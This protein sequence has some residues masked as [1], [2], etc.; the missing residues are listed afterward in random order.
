MNKTIITL[1][2]LLSVMVAK[3]Q[4]DLGIHFLPQTLQSQQANPALLNPYRVNIALPSPSVQLSH[5]GFSAS[6][7][8]RPLPGTDSL[9]L[10][11][12]E[13]ISQLADQNYVRANVRMDILGLGLRFNNL[14]VSLTASARAHLYANYPR[15][16]LDLAWRGNAAFLGQ[17][18]EIGPEFA[19]FAYSELALGAAY[20]FNNLTIGGRLKYLNGLANAE[21]GSGSLQLYTD[22]EYYQ[23]RGTLDYSFET[24]LIDLGTFDNFSP[25]FEFDP[26]T[27]NSGF[28]LDIGATYT[29]G[30]R[31]QI[32]A[33]LLD[34][35]SINWN[36]AARSYR[37]TGELT[38]DGIDV[39][40]IALGDSTYLDRLRDSLQSQIVLSEE[41]VQ[42]R[43]L[44]PMQ[45]MAGLRFSPLSKLHINGLIYNERYRGQNYPGLSLGVSKDFG[46]IFTLGASYNIRHRAYNQLGLQMWLRLGPFAGF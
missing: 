4:I 10:N 6:Q 34:F 40:A 5:S 12:D 8:L 36:D 17:S 31:L 18:L 41:P 42:Y 43:T 22:E 9:T 28:A 15:E 30:E 44:L 46:K 25:S 2:L 39:A 21:N 1:C 45:M 20:Q 3:A 13:V 35:G 16:L 37:A 14:Q 23:L 11:L 19:A 38:F 24:S 27:G 29:F 32:H 7:L 26:L 33:S